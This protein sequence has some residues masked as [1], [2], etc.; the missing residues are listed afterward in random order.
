[1]K[2]HCSTAKEW[3]NIPPL[4]MR[5]VRNKFVEFFRLA[6]SI[7]YNWLHKWFDCET[8]IQKYLNFSFLYLHCIYDCLLQIS[9]CYIIRYI[10]LSLILR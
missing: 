5:N 3:L 10:V 1:M 8:K 2:E 6:A 4:K 7:F 9:M